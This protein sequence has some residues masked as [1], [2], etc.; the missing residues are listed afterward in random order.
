[1]IL[2]WLGTPAANAQTADQPRVAKETEIRPLVIMVSM[3]QCCADKAWIE[4]EKRILIELDLLNLDV[5][6]IDGVATDEYHQQTELD[7]LAEQHWAALAIRLTRHTQG[8]RVELWIV[9]RLNQKTTRR[10]LRLE[11]VAPSEKPT[12]A[13]L[14]T[15]EA[16]RVSLHELRLTPQTREPKPSP[17]KA[18]EALVL[19]S[20]V[21]AE[22]KNRA[23]SL[24][25]GFSAVGS[26]GGVNTAGVLNAALGW[27]PQRSIAIELNGAIS[28]ITQDIKKDD[29]STSFN[30]A[31]GRLN[32]VWEF[33]RLNVFRFSFGAFGGAAVLWT[34]G[35]SIGDHPTKTDSAWTGYL[36][37][38]MRLGVA[39]L[40]Q[41]IINLDF[42]AGSLFPAASI[43]LEQVQVAEFG[44]PLFEGMVS[45]ETRFML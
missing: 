7:D 27:L 3:Q 25:M 5:R 6:S 40:E 34:Q 31:S 26:P 29:V 15:I 41:L 45:I 42:N 11:E 43:E 18:I 10:R 13:A 8:K 22:K 4:A 20:P 37:G 30:L 38:L 17:P 19:E 12:I 44:R 2:I 23:I 28:L 33:M 35:K 9:D 36:G 32:L 14:K 39:P 1:M 24:K 16:L 21:L